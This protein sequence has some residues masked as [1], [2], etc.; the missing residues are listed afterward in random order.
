L[1]SHAAPETLFPVF[2]AVLELR[3]PNG[4]Q[5][6]GYSRFYL[7]GRIKVISFEMSFQSREEKEVTGPTGAG[8]LGLLSLPES[9]NSSQRI[10]L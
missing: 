8:G 10:A 9:E 2:I 4:L 6:I 3:N 1:G 7:F 5:L